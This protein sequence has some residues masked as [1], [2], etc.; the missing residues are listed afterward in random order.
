MSDVLA[1]LAG[2]EASQQVL[3]NVVR[4]AFTHLEAGQ[5][6]M[7]AELQRLATGQ[8]RLEAGQG[9]LA[10]GQSALRLDLMARMGRLQDAASAI[11]DDIAMIRWVRRP[12][13][14][15]LQAP[16]PCAACH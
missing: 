6:T 15:A 2:L 7:R 14:A 4:N 16:T 8:E 1:A 9:R 10:T 13:P 12:A 3:H 5:E 11:R